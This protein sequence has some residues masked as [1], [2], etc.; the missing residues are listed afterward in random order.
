MAAQRLVLS[1][2][3]P[4]PILALHYQGGQYHYNSLDLN[5]HKSLLLENTNLKSDISLLQNTTY[6]TGSSTTKN[7]LDTTRD[8]STG[9]HITLN[10]IHTTN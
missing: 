10:M 8:P 5:D 2:A 6:C 4:W 7:P 3:Q 1:P 9:I